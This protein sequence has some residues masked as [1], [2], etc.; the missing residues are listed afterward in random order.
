MD[1][2]TQVRV[3][4]CLDPL[5]N[6]NGMMLCAHLSG[7]DPDQIMKAASLM[8][9]LAAEAATIVDSGC[10]INIMQFI[11]RSL[12]EG[13]CYFVIYHDAFLIYRYF[14]SYGSRNVQTTLKL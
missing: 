11:T 9:A 5:L 13:K 12:R 10:I 3:S 6:T 1:K 4:W 7:N 14:Y 2:V 8:A